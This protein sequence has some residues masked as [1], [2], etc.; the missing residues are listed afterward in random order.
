M[1]EVVIAFERVVVV[2]AL[3]VN[4]F[5]TLHAE[6]FSKSTC[7]LW[8]LSWVF[9]YSNSMLYFY[10]VTWYLQYI[11][12]VSWFWLKCFATMIEKIFLRDKYK[13]PSKVEVSVERFIYDVF[14]FCNFIIPFFI[15][16]GWQGSF[17]NFKHLW[18][19]IEMSYFPTVWKT[20]TFCL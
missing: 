5:F 3:V 9:C 12:S 16:A 14:Q 6:Y 13:K 7:T 8:K 15:F 11:C 17:C 4:L 10:L 2:S 20:L 1:V 18:G 19:L